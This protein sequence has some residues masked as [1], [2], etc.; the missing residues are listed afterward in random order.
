LRSIITSINL[1]LNCWPKWPSAGEKKYNNL[2]YL[3]IADVGLMFKGI[4]LELTF[5]RHTSSRLGFLRL[6]VDFRTAR[7]SDLGGR[8]SLKCLCSFGWKTK[9]KSIISEIKECRPYYVDW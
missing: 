8:C 5:V 9:G 1:F 4:I 2:R 6:E 7:D 3:R